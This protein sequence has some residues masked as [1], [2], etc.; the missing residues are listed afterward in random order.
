MV[1][2]FISIYVSLA[3]TLRFPYG[4]RKVPYGLRTR[5]LKNIFAYFYLDWRVFKSLERGERKH[6][7]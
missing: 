4:N 5:N 6:F 7:A 3:G 2:S 1:K